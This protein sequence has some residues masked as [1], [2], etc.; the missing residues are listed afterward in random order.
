MATDNSILKLQ[1]ISKSYSSPDGGDL[2][3]LE[4]VN[5]SVQSGETIGITGPS[6]SG[7]STLLNI[8]GTLDTATSGNILLQGQDI[9]SLDEKNL[10]RVRNSE[11]GFVFQS[12]HL[13]PQCTVLENV[14]VP[15]LVSSD[16]NSR[17]DRARQLLERVGLTSRLSHRPALLSGGERQRVAVVRSL[18][19]SPAL[20]LADEPTG[21]LNRKGAESLVDLLMELNGEETTTII[22]VTHS[23]RLAK[24]MGRALAL[25]DGRLIEQ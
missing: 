1:D 12:H 19:N 22:M 13:L 14:L 21:S 8:M 10:A 20:L 11:I 9:S 18:I 2:S 24:R 23:T 5:L 16:K 7:K 4:S 25:D 17:E 15:T 3:V 6:G